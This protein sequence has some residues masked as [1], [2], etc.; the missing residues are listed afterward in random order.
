MAGE[1][2]VFGW[3]FNFSWHDIKLKIS[4]KLVEQE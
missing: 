2:E 4:E 3:E 1:Y